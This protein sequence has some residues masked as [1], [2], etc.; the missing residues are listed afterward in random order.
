M[1]LSL[2]LNV[3]A[4]TELAAGKQ[5]FKFGNLKSNFINGQ[6]SLNGVGISS[7]GTLSKYNY[8]LWVTN[9]HAGLDFNRRFQSKNGV[10]ALVGVSAMDG[11]RARAAYADVSYGKWKLGVSAL[12]IAAVAVNYRNKEDNLVEKAPDPEPA[13][14]KPS[15][16][17]PVVEK[18]KPKP[19]P[20]P[21][22]V[23]KPKTDP[24]PPVNNCWYSRLGH[25]LD[26]NNQPAPKPDPV[27]PVDNCVNRSVTGECMDNFHGEPEALN[28]TGSLKDKDSKKTLKPPKDYKRPDE[29]KDFFT[30]IGNWF[31]ETD[32]PGNP[33]EKGIGKFF[34]NAGNGVYH[35]TGQA[36]TDAGNW[37][38][39]AANN[40][41]DWFSDAGKWTK[42]A[43]VGKPARDTHKWIDKAADDTYNWTGQAST[44]A[45]EWTKEAVTGKPARDTHEWI[46]KATEN[47]NKWGHNASIDAIEWTKDAFLDADS[48]FS[49]I[50]GVFGFAGQANY[51]MNRTQALDKLKSSTNVELSYMWSKKT[52]LTVNGTG[53]LNARHAI[54][55]DSYFVIEGKAGRYA[56]VTYDLKF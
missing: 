39:D 7:N 21:P 50:F 43:V 33:T 30:S 19:E 1:A 14:P 31:A 51:P 49:G 35:W 42:E 52:L 38:T 23:D 29:A 41:G 15:P 54:S 4:N 11:L 25:C 8:S 37:T 5:D 20:V 26:S 47:A 3:S 36:S 6:Q 10:S 32:K 48:W 9:G 13:K 44:D 28:S 18:P 45:G 34:S 24:V 22:V 16:K 2:S 40:T 56:K 12:V 27:P 46:D 55:V 17:P 53:A